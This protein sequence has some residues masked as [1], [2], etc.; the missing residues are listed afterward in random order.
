MAERDGGGVAEGH[1]HQANATARHAIEKALAGVS[2]AARSLDD[3]R[4]GPARRN[5]LRD[6]A[7]HFRAAAEAA[8]DALAFAS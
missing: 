7:V 3:L 1:A 6:A 4:S 8:D 2:C 5:D